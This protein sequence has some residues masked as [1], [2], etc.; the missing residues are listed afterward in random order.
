MIPIESKKTEVVFKALLENW[1]QVFSPPKYITLDSG[2]E[3]F[4]DF[5]SEQLTNV[6]I[7]PNYKPKGSHAFVVEERNRLLKETLLEIRDSHPDWSLDIV[8]VHVMRVLNN[9]IG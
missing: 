4:S 8:L 6:G 1:F 2:G 5:W 7:T 3:F 9:L